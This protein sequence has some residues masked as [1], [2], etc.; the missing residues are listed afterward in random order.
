MT[1][2]C[3]PPDEQDWKCKICHLQLNSVKCYKDHMQKS[4][5]SP[6]ITCDLCT[7]QV[8]DER[9]EAHRKTCEK[10]FDEKYA[11]NEFQ[12]NQCKR[13]YKSEHQLSRHKTVKHSEGEFKCDY[14][15]LIFKTKM[16][17]SAHVK[18]I[19]LNKVYTCHLCEKTF[20]TNPRLVHHMDLRHKESIIKCEFC[21]KRV[22]MAY[23]KHT[24]KGKRE[25]TKGSRP[26]KE[27]FDCEVCAEK[28][29]TI[30][31]LKD[32]M[33]V[34]HQSSK[35]YCEYCAK[36][37]TTENFFN[38]VENCIVV[39]QE[40]YTGKKYQCDKCR[41][42]FDIYGTLASHRKQ[43]HRKVK[44]SCKHCGKLFSKSTARN[45]HEKVHEG[46]L[47]YCEH[48]GKSFKSTANLKYHMAKHHDT[49]PKF[50]CD[51]CP[52][53]FVTKQRLVKHDCEALQKWK[54]DEEKRK[55]KAELQLISE[56][57]V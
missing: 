49:G 5:K 44:Y 15:D 28:L 22:Y 45:T 13:S 25:A 2:K 32:H 24:C 27:H 40:K 48:C 1:A 39:Y 42:S 30:V 11:N 3:L 50:F 53:T 36:H 14:C 16:R 9:F 31:E 10:V 52:E 12:C 34:N 29:S 7:N 19:H 37:I 17:R 55:R 56:L 23:E 18:I 54:I 4:H 51:R 21:Q 38:H 46:I 8:L 6:R 26:E 41:R 33:V 57:Q 43:I 47:L 20:D 35:I